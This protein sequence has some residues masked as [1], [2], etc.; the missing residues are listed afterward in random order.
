MLQ[1][2]PS[3]LIT[4]R[5]LELREWIRNKLQQEEAK[6]DSMLVE[7]DLYI[8]F[9]TQI[10]APMRMITLNPLPMQ[11]IISL[12]PIIYFKDGEGWITTKRPP[13]FDTHKV[14]LQGPL[15]IIDETVTGEF[16]YVVVI[17]VNLFYR[18][19]DLICL[20][21]TPTI[22]VRSYVDTL[23]EIFLMFEDIHPQWTGNQVV[24]NAYLDTN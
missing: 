11:V 5:L 1:D 6:V 13:T 9:T 14:S 12:S 10:V 4:A 17:D 8:R 18:S 15:N 2:R 19:S 24:C 21:L 20:P 7:V 3:S 23:L 22:L 16:E